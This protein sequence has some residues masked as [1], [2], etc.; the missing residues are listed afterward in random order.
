[1][2][3]ESKPRASCFPISLKSKKNMAMCADPALE[4]VLM[5]LMIADLVDSQYIYN[6]FGTNVPED[7]VRKNGFTSAGCEYKSSLARVGAQ[8]AGE[9]TFPVDPQQRTGLFPILESSTLG[10]PH[11]GALM[12]S[13]TSNIVIYVWV[14]RREPIQYVVPC[15]TS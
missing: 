1:M 15:K 9:R 12:M 11:A 4:M 2:S 8:R 5:S 6:L 10:E 7:G 3:E 13:I 14:R